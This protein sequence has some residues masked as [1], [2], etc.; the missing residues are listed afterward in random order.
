MCVWRGGSGLQGKMLKTAFNWNLRN[1]NKVWNRNLMFFLTQMCP[2]RI[3][4]CAEIP[5]PLGVSSEAKVCFPTSY[6][7]LYLYRLSFWLIHHKNTIIFNV[8]GNVKNL[9]KH[10]SKELGLPFK[11]PDDLI[12]LSFPTLNRL[13]PLCN[14]YICQ[15][16]FFTFSTY[17]HQASQ[18]PLS[19]L[20]H[21]FFFARNL[22]FL[23]LYF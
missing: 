14:F 10:W 13:R 21:F 22:L 16:K 5:A 15:N 1:R 11:A 6:H 17:T 19:L 12:S 3:H 23:F 2:G 9:G 4:R 20:W 8:S 18:L 7:H